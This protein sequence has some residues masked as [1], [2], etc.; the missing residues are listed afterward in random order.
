VKVVDA[1][2]VGLGAVGSAATWQLAKRG[3]KVLGIDR[4]TPPHAFGSTHGE[5]RVTRLAIGEGEQ[6][7][8][9]VRRSHEI[10]REIEAATGTS[11]LTVTGGL[12]ISSGARLAETH[13]AN[14]FD[15][16]VATAK[17]HGIDHQILD[18]HAIRE[19]FPQFRVRDNETAY[20][21]PGAGFVRPE[22]C[23]AAQLELAGR[24]GAELVY[25]ETVQ[26]FVQD[27][28][29]VRVVTDRGEYAAK[30]VVVA[31]GAW[32]PQ[33]VDA[34]LGRLFTVTRQV[35]YWYE[36]KASLAS[37]SPPAFP[38][39]IWELQDRNNVIYGFPAIDGA[40]GGAKVAT[41]QYMVTTS[42]DAVE[43][44]VSAQETRGMY[45]QLVAPNL[46][47]L[48]PRCIKAVSCLYTATPDFHFVIDRHPR[49]PGVILA[50]PCSGHGFKHSA[51]IGE[52]LAQL[53]AKGKSDVDLSAFSL[54]R[55]RT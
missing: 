47:G 43:R 51:A 27:G 34:K 29:I 28:D 30:Q 7:V 53:M 52:A 37:F 19:R 49:M 17:R 41:E 33:L 54:R 46:A 2:V 50:S 23:V 18:A 8:P 5:T 25:G 38:I 36:V 26:S 55:F 4:F 11:L 32:L 22:T 35:L 21:E 20:Y 13:V 12:I 44:E 10:W 14:F 9:L 31:A 1:I 40:A 3:A 42:V 6:Y 48:G 24:G 45:E 16:T 39:W 15:N